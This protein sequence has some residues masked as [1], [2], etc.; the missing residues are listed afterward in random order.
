MHGARIGSPSQYFPLDWIVPAQ[1]FAEPPEKP[2][3]PVPPHCIWPWAFLQVVAQHTPDTQ[4]GTHG[5][6]LASALH[7]TAACRMF[8]PQQLAAPPGRLPQ[9][10]LPHCSAPLELT[11]LIEQQ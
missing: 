7:G 1:Q 5:A 10:V 3:Q 4:F 8:V 9:P 11:Q 6:L 2:L